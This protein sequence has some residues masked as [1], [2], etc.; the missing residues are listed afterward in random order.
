VVNHVSNSASGVP[1]VS[2]NESVPD[3][4]Y[5]ASEFD[6]CWAKELYA[7]IHARYLEARP[8]HE[9]HWQIF[10]ARIQGAS[11]RQV[12]VEHQTTKENVNVIRYRV[13]ADVNQIRRYLEDEDEALAAKW[14]ATAPR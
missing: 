1:T 7:L 5:A 11:A 9:R 14:A 8:G 3:R 2:L 13:Q 10:M 12:A 6:K 4:R